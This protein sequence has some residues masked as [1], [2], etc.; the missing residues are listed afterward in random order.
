MNMEDLNN[1]HSNKN[2][3]SDPLT[4]FKNYLAGD[5]Q[6]RESSG[7]RKP[8]DSGQYRQM[9]TYK[10]SNA[11]VSRSS[12]PTENNQPSYQQRSE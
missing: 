5:K 9:E 8:Y 1:T 6:N 3:S 2:P 12:Y 10:A 4:N 11:I 7:E